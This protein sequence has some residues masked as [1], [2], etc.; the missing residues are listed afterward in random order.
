MKGGDLTEEF[1]K[2][3]LK[4]KSYIKKSTVYDLHYK[5]SNIRNQKGK[6]LVL[7]ELHK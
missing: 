2:A 6:K 4:Y 1:S 7:L 5:P 3:E